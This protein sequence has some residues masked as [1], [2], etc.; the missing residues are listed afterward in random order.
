MR[1]GQKVQALPWSAGKPSLAE[2]RRGYHLTKAL[3]WSATA[4]ST[5]A[6]GVTFVRMPQHI[7]ERDWKLF[8]KLRQLALER[9]CERTLDEVKNVMAGA[10]ASHHA[11]YIEVFKVIDRRDAELALVFDDFRRSTSRT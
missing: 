10:A 3:A 6:C 9:F 4:G 8:A 11:R 7:P 1:L 2:N 5:C